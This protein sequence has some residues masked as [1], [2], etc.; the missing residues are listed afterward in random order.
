MPDADHYVIS[1]DYPGVY[2]NEMEQLAGAGC[3]ALLINGA[4][5]NQAIANPKNE[6]GWARLETV[7]KLLAAK[8]NDLRKTID[9]SELKL[10]LSHADPELP[11]SLAGFQP[12][13]VF[14]QQLEIGDLVLD[15]VPGEPVVEI[16][17]ELRRRALAR[18]YKAQFTVGLSNDYLNYFVT[19]EL[20]PGFYYETG[21]SFFGPG[22]AD[23]FYQQFGTLYSKGEAPAAPALAEAPTPQ[24]LGDIKVVR[25]KGDDRAIGQQRGQ[26]FAEDIRAKFDERVFQ[27]VYTGKAFPKTGMWGMIPPFADTTKLVPALMGGAV[28]PR[29]EGISKGLYAEVEGM[30][31]GAKLP[32]DAVWLLQ[33]ARDAALRE[34]KAPLFVAPLCTMFTASAEDRLLVGRNLDWDLAETPTVVECAPKDGQRYLQIGFT[35]NAGVFTGMNE[36]GVVVCVEHVDGQGEPELRAAPLELVLRDILATK[37]TAADA[38]AVLKAQTGQHGHHVL[39]AGPGANGFESNVVEFGKEITVRGPEDGVLLGVAPSNENADS[40]SLVRH[41][42]VADLLATSPSRGVETLQKVLCDAEPNRTGRAQIWNSAT[43]HAVVFDPQKKSIYVSFPT[44]DGAPGAFQRVA[45]T[46]AKP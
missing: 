26:L 44:K 43:K 14:I 28:R 13:N 4:E 46:G 15:F 18:G 39:V 3:V 35:W 20:Y 23:W 27:A 45:F 1:A 2:Y 40:D 42:R 16:G 33:N 29:L 41:A 6:D 22:M 30:A 36:A 24:T 8:A 5:G 25:L 9:C 12:R 11:P 7:A 38:V 21:M 19:R 17:L 34:D 32:F 31:E 10:R 37:T